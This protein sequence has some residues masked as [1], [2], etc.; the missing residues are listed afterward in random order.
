MPR[1]PNW[2][3]ILLLIVVLLSLITAI[4]VNDRVKLG[5]AVTV[6]VTVTPRTRGVSAGFRTDVSAAPAPAPA[7]NNPPS[8]VPIVPL[9][10]DTDEGAY[11]LRIKMGRGQVEAV[12][13]TGSSHISAKGA[14]CK[15]T[16]CGGNGNDDDDDDDDAAATAAAPSTTCVTK[17]C[18]CG[19][20]ITGDGSAAHVR[21]DCNKF[22]YVPTGRLVQPGQDGAGSSTKL[23]YGSQEDTISHYLD[24][25]SLPCTPGSGVTCAVLSDEAHTPRGNSGD[26]ND[27]LGGLHGGERQ[28][29]HT[30][31][32]YLLGAM[33]VHLVHH[34][35]GSS[36]SNLFGLARP[37]VFA[38]GGGHESSRYVVL[39]KLL[40]EENDDKLA[41]AAAAAVTKK[42]APPSSPRVWSLVLRKQGGWFALGALDACFRAVKYAPLVDPS[43]FRSF[44][45]H[46]YIVD[47]VSME[48]GP[49]LSTLVRVRK[50]EPRYCLVDTGT[51]YT[52]GSVSLGASLAALG[53]V[54][55]R[56]FVRF[57][58][59]RKSDPIVLT[60]SAAD[61]VDRDFPASS[62]MQCTEGK[63]LPDF[64]KLFPTPNVVLFGAL[65]MQNMY[66]E[67]D[68]IRKRMGVQSLGNEPRE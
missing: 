50:N 52:Y 35:Q 59:G 25:V 42:R 9:W 67:F 54:E 18:P 51:T 66:W 7:P 65:M 58:L 5:R 61:L 2:V 49:S 53:Y 36:S 29:A 39:E 19:T 34:I 57:T 14:S 15:W 46:F 33:I 63:T 28:N 41:A 40:P 27:V 24:D 32:E 23:V 16:Y 20:E 13:D 31:N 30:P 44:I 26:D 48:V 45:T 56:W 62:V 64:D 21:T 43:I 6:A 47:I 55:S 12:L 37:R 22:F 10:W 68:L 8:N 1:V 4:Y 60:Y 17:A 11:M 3:W 38:G